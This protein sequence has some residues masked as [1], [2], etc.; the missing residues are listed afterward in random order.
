ME[1]HLAA[2]HY[3]TGAPMRIAVADGRFAA[4]ELWTG[5]AAGLPWIAPGLVDLQVNG[6]GG[7]D[8]NRLPADPAAWARAHGALAAHGCT[9]FLATLIT[10]APDEGEAL[11]RAL[12]ARRAESP[13]G[14]LGFHLEG[15][16][17]NPDPGTRGAHDAARMIPADLSLLA[18]WQAA[19]GG[20]VRLVTLAPEIAPE[21]ALPF[22]RQ[23]RAAGVRAAIGHSLAMGPALADAVEA[24]ADAWIHL[25]NALPRQID[26]FENPFFHVLADERLRAFLIPDGLHVPPPAFRALARALGP[27]LLLTTDAMSAAG[28]AGEG[29]FTLGAQEVAVAADGRATQPGT[30]RL[31]GSTLTPFRGVFQAAALSGLPWNDLWDAFSLRPAAWIGLSHGLEKGMPADFCLFDTE[32]EPR[33]RSVYRD[34]ERLSGEEPEEAV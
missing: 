31:A 20:A 6:F 4:F 12:A 13:G 29:P 7:A 9:R 34:G 33:L 18:R 1:F 3:R 8:F 15:P 19:A 10:H 26:K 28:A 21:R 22:L 14:C 17:L 5:P 23:L 32:R 11:L 2:R 25:G 30:G 16:F 24:G 27:R